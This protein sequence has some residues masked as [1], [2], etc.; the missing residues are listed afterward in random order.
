LSVADVPLKTVDAGELVQHASRTT[1]RDS[2]LHFRSDGTNRY[3]DPDRAYGVLYLGYDL[4]TVLMESIF[5]EH[6]WHRQ[7]R[8]TIT[9]NEAARRMVR[10]I[11]VLVDL[12]LADLTAPDVMA[13]AFGLNLSQLASRRYMHTQRIS[14]A[15]H[16]MTDSIGTPLYDGILY[17]SRNNYPAACIALFERA[18]AKVDVFADI[19]LIKHNDWPAFVKTY[20]ISV[21]PR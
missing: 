5:H 1:Y 16:S 7:K 12:H 19:D 4:Q 11:G 9:R 2:A 20:E 18:K 21:L 8:R 6:Q 10:V 14:R 15:I 13:T 3:D 17:P